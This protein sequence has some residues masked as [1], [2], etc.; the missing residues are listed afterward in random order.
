M[1][2]QNSKVFGDLVKKIDVDV[3]NDSIHKTL[4]EKVFLNLSESHMKILLASSHIIPYEELDSTLAL[5]KKK[6]EEFDK[7]DLE[8][9]YIDFNEEF[10]SIIKSYWNNL[11]YI[12]KKETPSSTAWLNT[13]NWEAK[14]NEL[15]IL[16]EN[17]IAMGA[18]KSREIDK[19]LSK[20]LK[21]RFNINAT[22]SVHVNE[23]SKEN[24]GC[25]DLDSII[26]KEEKEFINQISQS[27]ALSS[28]NNNKSDKTKKFN[29]KSDIPSNIIFGKKINC[30]V[31]KISDVN[32]NTGVAA[33]EGEVFDVEVRELKSKKKLYIFNITDLSSSI[34]V[35]VFGNNKSSEELDEKLTDGLYV[36]VQGD[37]IYDT[38]SKELVVMGKT[39]M[40]LDKPVTR[41]DKCDL[42]RVEL[43]LHTQMSD[44]DGMSNFSDIAKRAAEW[45]HK[46]IGLT[47]HGV[48][49]AFPEGMGAAKKHGI[50]VLYGL[51]GYVVNDIVTIVSRPM[52]KPLDC[53]YVVFDIETT[54]LSPRNDRITEI[55]AVKIEK[56]VIVDRFSH[57]IN[58]EITIP[59][60]IIEL[61][62]I[63]DEMVMDKP[64]IDRV[65]PQF[66]DFIKGSTLVAHNAT[67]D[68][69]F[70][71]EKLTQIGE[72][73]NN[74]VLDTLELSRRLFPDLKSHKLNKVAKHLKVTLENHHRAVDDSVATAHILLKCIEILR[75]RG[76]SK[77][78]EVNTAFSDNVD[79]YKTN[80]SYHI[81][82]FA[83]NYQGLK[84]L[85]KLVSKSHIE[86]FY[87]RPR[88]PKSVLSQHREGLIIGT[89]CEAGELYRAILEKKSNLDIKNI[90]NFYDYLEI[91]PLGNNNFLIENGMVK[92]KE[93]LRNINR[94]ISQL[95]EKYNKPV[96]ATGDVHFLDPQD[97]IYRRILMT[98]KGFSDAD[99]Q[100]PLYFRTTEEML[101]EFSYLGTEKAKEVVIDNTNMIADMIDDILPIPDG[102]YPPEIKG[103]EEELKK[104]TVNKA[105][106]MYG[107]PLPEIVKNRLDRELN[108]IISNGYAV[109]YIISHKL[110]KKSLED[111]YLV[112][113]RGSVGSSF[114]ATMS[115]IT[116]VNPLVPHY[117]CP[118]CKN[119][120]FFTDGS[121][122][123]GVDLEDKICPKCGTDYI[124]DGYDIPFETFLGFEGDKEP[125][126]D[127]NFAGEYQSVA[128]HYTEELFGKG[129]VFRAGTI[130]T[131]ADKTA[132]GFVKKY[133]DEKEKVL[134]K[135]E[136]NRLIKGCAGVKRTS[137]Q[138]PGGVMVVPGNKEIYDFTPIQYPANDSKSGVI[139]THFDYHSISGRILKLD[140]LGHDTPTIIRMLEDITGVNA[141]KIPMDD[142][143]TMKIFTS[144][145]PLGIKPEDINNK[146]GT[147]GIP[148]FG[149]KFVIQMLL[150][151]QPTSFSDLVRISG[152]SHGTDVWLNNAQDLV[153]NS[154]TDLRGV[155]ATR[156]DIM[157]YLIFQGLDKKKSFMIM[158]K[159]RKGKGL[160]EDEEEYMREYNVP[161][162]YITSCKTIKY[163][164]PKAHAAAYV[165][166]SFRIAY[167]K[168]HYPE[169]FYATYFTMKAV[170]F[171]AELI[172]KGKEAAEKKIKELEEMGN[173][174]TAKEKNLLTVLEVALELYVRGFSFMKVDLYNSDSDKFLI[175][176]E[177]I[178]PPLKSL[179]GVGENAARS[180][181]S[182]RENG[183][184][185]S[186]E[187][188][189]NRCKVTKTVIEAL[190]EH[191]CLEGMSQS[192]QLSLFNI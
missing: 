57:L 126:I 76:V 56:G 35:K 163:M 22:V 178:L 118:K 156:D 170:D 152:L 46:A 45:G 153:R 86:F 61:T 32:T 11:L 175:K 161:E 65:L 176:K 21:E 147:F 25:N 79:S 85:Y 107:D 41:Q 101:D 73:I 190:K 2:R 93:E 157:T 135:A 33:F 51:E 18:L 186:I 26:K 55:G 87:R 137:G 64:T 179:Q 80:K 10:E 124:K 95:G 184:F 165:M 120:E 191:G 47:D 154:V 119:S 142:K 29:K 49:Q 83:Q 149:T 23:N 7:V 8:V 167:F 43:H 34:T 69:G 15:K 182:A 84:N 31:I 183:D 159:V 185:L 173:N 141:Q 17:D 38:F 110:V 16:V 4:V 117:V 122:G 59:K 134:N 13:I 19:Y 192:N 5:L 113:S 171:D 146:T 53:S 121:V 174:K 123:A 40:T 52:D 96:V 39:I 180:I 103:S 169:A 139:T 63:T 100:P 36:R 24:Q 1:L 164:F 130:G 172:V 71:Q 99:N 133:F 92:D 27:Q 105:I 98:G 9:K 58:P 166:M 143:A 177:G 72:K 74:S 145:E 37:V 115:D 158:E 82:I 54:G 81:I 20:H 12:I 108:S 97:E 78:S 148:E 188:I 68:M 75:D 3:K 128:H 162:W 102:T 131:I 125:D 104:I 111:G 94:K 77:L 50:K 28:G 67:F 6:F 30:E 155:I 14:D 106:E 140:I 168:V 136:A 129:Y 109:L 48:V 150:D 89:A 127:L 151:T 189:Q 60:K 88:I 70:I 144:T 181:A 187:D 42:K 114:V 62:G 138:H 90:V 44:M 116:E 91:Q 112:G 66:L 160:A 132:Y